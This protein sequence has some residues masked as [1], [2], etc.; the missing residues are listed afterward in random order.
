ML[1]QDADLRLDLESAGPVSNL[2]PDCSFSINRQH[3][4]DWLCRAVLLLVCIV[5]WIPRFTGPINFRWDASAYYILGTALSQGHGYRLLN[6]PGEIEAVQYPPLLPMI[7]AAVQ[8]VMATTDFFKVG[9]ALRLTYFVFSALLLLMSYALVRKLLSPVYALIVGVMMAISF[10][11][12]LEPSDVLYADLPFALAS[13]G[14]LLCQQKSDR[15]MFAAAS[16]LLVAAAYLFRT[17]GLALFLAWIAES[18]IRRRFG[19][20]AIRVA[21]CALPI[22]LWQAHVWRVTR[23]YEY[24]PPGIFVSARRLLLPERNLCRE[25]PAHRSI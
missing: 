19:Q 11:T 10:S 4:R 1:K 7:V 18:L 5:I 15:P 25:Q 21:I 3:R 14:F 17:A 12:M 13:V 8:S 24:Q 22:L 2:Q 23:S 16:G 9:C 6:E 20:A